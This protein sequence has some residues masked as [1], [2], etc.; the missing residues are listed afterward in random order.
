M[1]II[2]HKFIGRTEPVTR[3]EVEKYPIRFF[4]MAIGATDPIHVD[5]EA[6]RAAGYRS[7]VAPPTYA[8]C[9]QSLAE[10]YESKMFADLGVDPGRVLHGE[11]GFSYHEPI[12]AG[13][14]LEFRT[15]ITDIY[16]KKG[17]ALE[18]IVTQTDITNQTGA[19]VAESR[20]VIVVRN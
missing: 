3:M 13:D 15:R 8:L 9:A 17:G 5:E 10:Q 2:D 16:D 1:H 11:Q 18:F 4:A 20:T 6:A 19:V 7:V 12:C 14:K